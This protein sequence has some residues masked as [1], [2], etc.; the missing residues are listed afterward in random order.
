[1]DLDEAILVITKAQRSHQS[2][3]ATD[4]RIQA[5]LVQ[6]SKI[7]SHPQWKGTNGKEKPQDTR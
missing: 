4:R 1:M 3:Q 2:E 6:F 7:R 5:M